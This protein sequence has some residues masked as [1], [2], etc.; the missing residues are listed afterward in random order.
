MQNPYSFTIGYGLT[1]EMLSYLLIL[2]PLKN[3]ISYKRSRHLTPYKQ[4]LLLMHQPTPKTAASI[5]DC[6]TG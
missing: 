3:Q 2:Q 1:L 4:T 6:Y 5:M